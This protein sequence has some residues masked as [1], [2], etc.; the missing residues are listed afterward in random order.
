[1]P[2]EKSSKVL[3]KNGLVVNEGRSEIKDV[4]IEG[5]RIERVE[6]H[7]SPRTNEKVI[8]ASGMW[9]LPG[10]IDDQVHFREP[11]LTRKAEIATESRAAVAG[12][13]TSYIEQPNTRPPAL[14]AEAVEEKYARA[15]ECSMANFGFNIGASNENLE[16]L[17]RLEKGRFPGVKVF[18]GSSTG[19]MLVDDEQML[20]GLFGELD[21][22]IIT[23]CEDETTI[24]NNL[25]AARQRFGADIPMDWHSRIRSEE[26]CFLSS[27]RAV[28]MARKKGARLHVYHLSTEKETALFDKGPIEGKKITAE[29]CVHHLWFTDNDYAAKGSLIKWNPAVKT[30]KDRAG[31]WKALLDDRI[32]VIATD[33]APHL[34]E[35]KMQPYEKA[36]SGGPLVQH[37][38]PAMLEFVRQDKI[39]IEWLVQRICHNPATL[40]RIQDRGYIRPGHYADLVIV[41]PSAPWTVTSENT[42]YKCG[43]SPFEG[44]S[45]KS[46]VDKTL[47]NGRVV[48]DR[49]RFEKSPM[50]MRLTHHAH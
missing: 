36:P 46:R 45:F 35:E 48:Y 4:L 21:Q 10:L 2:E 18:M 24:Q 1:M 44:T 22:L 43:W 37:F 3:I 34:L 40:F 19:N 25:E 6:Q 26:A 11:G 14:T 38:L 15:A 28:E 5:Q 42:L 9:V 33:H 50:G 47:V 27:S 16:E 13:I 41:E 29:A 17:K 20:E 12:G 39:K 7:I 31:L 8:D 30:E 23:H 32:D 49:G